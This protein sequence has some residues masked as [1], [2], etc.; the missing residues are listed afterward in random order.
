[1]ENAA[2]ALL[3]TTGRV[4]NSKNVALWCAYKPSAG[5]RIFKRPS[6]DAQRADGPDRCKDQRVRE[7]G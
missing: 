7:G 4:W 1:M 2:D 5:D 3:P 6:A